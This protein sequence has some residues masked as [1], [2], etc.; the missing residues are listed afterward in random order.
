MNPEDVR[1][2]FMGSPAFAVPSLRALADGGYAVEGVITQPDRPAGRG[3]RMVAPEVKI[4]ALELGLN[5]MQ[6]GRLRDY[7]LHEELRLLRPDVFVVAAYGKILPQSVLDIPARGCVNVHASLLPRWRGAS[8]IAA[9]ILAGDAETGVSIMEMVLEMDAGPVIAQGRTPI[10]RHDTTG[11]LEPRLAALGADLLVDV[12]PRWYVGDV[13][14]VGQDESLVTS[15]GLME[16]R[17]GQLAASMT[18]EDA[19]RAVRA[20]NPWPGAS[21]LYGGGPLRIW[22]ARAVRG[23]G[24]PPGTM[25]TVERSPAVAMDGGLLL[26]D[27]VQRPGGKRITGQQFLAGERGQLAS[28]V[29]LA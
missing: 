1:V 14:A 8:P 18:T 27:E 29:G 6:P 20:Y 9:A 24:G 16:K 2:V 26:L 22:R 28:T 7:S 21:V 19:E 23:E 10:G 5:V 3:G 4:A 15:C 12:L 17:D 11:S 13:N 25:L